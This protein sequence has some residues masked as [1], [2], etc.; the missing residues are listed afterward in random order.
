MI[1]GQETRR[2]MYGDAAFE[3]LP[4]HTPPWL[5][6][7]REN[8]LERLLELMDAPSSPSDS[9][10]DDARPVGK[11]R[12]EIVEIMHKPSSYP[13][14]TEQMLTARLPTPPPSDS[15]A[16]INSTSCLQSSLPISGKATLEAKRGKKRRLDDTQEEVSQ[17]GQSQMIITE[18]CQFP[19]SCSR[20]PMVEGI[21]RDTKVRRI[22]T[23][24][25]VEEEEEEEEEGLRRLDD[26]EEKQEGQNWAS[27]SPKKKLRT[28]AIGPKRLRRNAQGAG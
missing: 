9:G 17:E 18:N 14:S 15:G 4:R 12:R 1:R 24:E 23:E 16:T 11:R 3:Y 7:K 13:F 19:L 26:V 27:Q 10:I 21:T 6:E 5:I 2:R 22:D 8:D 28:I 25:V 20:K